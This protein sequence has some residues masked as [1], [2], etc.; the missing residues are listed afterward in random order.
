MAYKNILFVCEGNKCRSPMAEGILRKMLELGRNQ[1]IALSSAGI[2]AIAAYPGKAARNA[3]LVLR[4]MGIDISNHI[5]KQLDEEMIKQNDL[6]LAMTREIKEEIIEM[7]PE[8]K[9]KIYTLG[10]FA[11]YRDFDIR[12]PIGRDI[13]VYREVAYEIKMLLERALDKINCEKI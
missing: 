1:K 2:A 11:G 8:S 12:D 10:E 6:I 4:E 9:A 5:T 13:E 7:H 3:I